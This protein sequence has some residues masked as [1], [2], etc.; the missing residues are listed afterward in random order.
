VEGSKSVLSDLCD[1]C[2]AQHHNPLWS[3][4]ALVPRLPWKQ[5]VTVKLGNEDTGLTSEQVL[6]VLSAGCVSLEECSIAHL[7]DWVEPLTVDLTPIVKAE[8]LKML[9]IGAVSVAPILLEHLILPSLTSLTIRIYN[10]CSME[11]NRTWELVANLGAR[12][13]SMRLTHLRILGREHFANAKARNEGLN[14]RTIL[15]QT[16]SHVSHLAV[17]G[18]SNEMLG[19]LTW[20]VDDGEGNARHPLPHLSV[21]QLTGFKADKDVLLDIIVSRIR[22]VPSPMLR[23]IH[24]TDQRP[25]VEEIRQEL[26]ARLP[27]IITDNPWEDEWLREEQCTYPF[28]YD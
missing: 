15:H 14:P 12:S 8:R 27:E 6:G 25:E 4:K 9:T 17:K 24:L 18:I 3:F 10:Y 20:V 16:F 22:G 26:Q 5:V 2:Q 23:R 1:S 11:T 19:A 13:Q 28:P 21:L 7:R